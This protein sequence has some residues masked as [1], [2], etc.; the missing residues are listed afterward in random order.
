M[1]LRLSIFRDMINRYSFPLVFSLAL[2][3]ALPLGLAGLALAQ[4]PEPGTAEEE[5]QAPS[6][7]P[8]VEVNMDALESLSPSREK[9]EEKAP[10][11]EADAPELSL[12]PS[13]PKDGSPPPLERPDSTAGKNDR[14]A[15]QS[16]E[17]PMMREGQSLPSGESDLAGSQ[18]TVLFDAG[19]ARLS[20]DASRLLD[21]AGGSVG[22]VLLAAKTDD[23]SE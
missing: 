17:A 15:A 23:R 12:L 7:T 22:S 14:P 2:C 19:A 21:E 11:P 10:A 16:P 4:E 3:L 20:L 18:L 13:Q 5:S 9:K 1:Q 8:G 6:S